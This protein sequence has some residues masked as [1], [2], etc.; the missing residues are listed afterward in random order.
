M[1]LPVFVFTRLASTSVGLL[2]G[3]IELVVFEKRFRKYNFSRKVATKFFIYMVLMLVIIAIAFPITSSIELSTSPLDPEV[4]KKTASFFQSFLFINTV[5]QI[6]FQLLLCLLY[7]AISENLGHQVLLNFFTG[8]Y[9]NPKEEQRIFMFLDMKNSTTIAE[10]LGH[11]QYFK[12]LEH[13]YE[14]M[15]DPIINSLGE[16]YQYIGDEVV[17]TW[18]AHKGLTNN[19][20][21]L[22]FERIKQNL[23]NHGPQFEKDL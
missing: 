15:T 14:I 1:T 9:H 10:Q 13:Y 22:C 5:V 21:I 4:L 7:A 16:V 20:C 3:L 12:L 18:D 6:S 17:I 11:D 2:I 19:H 8:R 23:K